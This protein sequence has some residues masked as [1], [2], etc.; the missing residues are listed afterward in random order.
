MES[1]FETFDAWKAD[2]IGKITSS[3]VSRLLVSGKKKGEY[4][5]QR[6]MTY[7]WEKVAEILTGESA[8]SFGRALEW[9]ASNEFDA[10]LEYQKRTGIDVEY[11][12]VANPKFFE[13]NSRSGGS[14]DGLT[15]D[16]L[17]EVKCPFNSGNHIKFLRMKSQQDL[18]ETSFEYY[19][20]SQMNLLCTKMDK[21]DFISY[22]PRIIDYR[23]R[24]S[25]LEIGRDEQL[26]KEIKERVN[27]A[28]EIISITLNALS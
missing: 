12:G 19:C 7:I 15:I 3:E 28:C 23:Y 8:E 20:Q 2:R 21:G 11:F 27:A 14:P 9:G 6:A 5:G 4:F 18:K 24:E 10:I 22:D 16:K 13:L 1:M 17:L 25:I 26:I